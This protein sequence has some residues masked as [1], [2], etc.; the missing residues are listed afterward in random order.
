M[1]NQPDID[2]IEKTDTD[3]EVKEP[4]MF[5]VV[6]LNDD[7]T[8]MDFVVMVLMH[9]FS[10]PAEEATVIMMSVHK[11]GSGIAGIYS[12]D[13]AETKSNLVHSLAKEAGFPL[14]TIVEEE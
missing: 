8:P 9:V 1:S 14:A 6:L 11:S 5:K 2:V 13:I 12:K 10:K 7:Y 3:E 4:S